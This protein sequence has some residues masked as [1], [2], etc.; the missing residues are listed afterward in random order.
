MAAID[1]VWASCRPLYDML[2]LDLPTYTLMT[3]PVLSLTTRTYT[4]PLRG[5]AIPALIAAIWTLFDNG[6]KPGFL[7]CP[8]ENVLLG[9]EG[10]LDRDWLLR[11]EFWFDGLTACG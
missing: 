2:S 5:D 6:E 10:L 8:L 1:R 9:D 4:T 7:L 11:G 3:F